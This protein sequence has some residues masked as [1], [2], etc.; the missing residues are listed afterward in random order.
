VGLPFS[1]TLFKERRYWR[2]V[3]VVTESTDGIQVEWRSDEYE[4]PWGKALAQHVARAPIKNVFI[5]WSSIEKVTY[6]GRFFGP[7]QLHITA[8][9]LTA[10]EEL[11]GAVGNTWWV[12]VAKGERRNA[13]E[14]ALT[15]E[16]AIASAKSPLLPSSTHRR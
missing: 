14:F 15:S 4:R 6:R 3:G 5:P 13:R 10:V 16:S 2:I 12:R 9:S 1:Q 8:R 11:P 7:G